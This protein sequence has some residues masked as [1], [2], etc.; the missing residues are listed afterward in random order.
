MSYGEARIGALALYGDLVYAP[1]G[2][3]ASRARTAGGLTGDA[4]LA[5]TGDDRRDGSDI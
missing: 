5:H 3:G 4:A 1:I 2:A